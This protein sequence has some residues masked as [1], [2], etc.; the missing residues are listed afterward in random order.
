MTFLNLLLLP[1]L[2][3]R[4][5]FDGEGAGGDTGDAGDPPTGEGKPAATPPADDKK[6]V[7]KPPSGSP[8]SVLADL[9]RERDK[10]QAAESEAKRLQGVEGELQKLREAS[11]SESEKA[12]NDAKREATTEERG[13]WEGVIRQTRVESA[14]I[15]AGCTDPEIVSRASVFADLKVTD[16]GAVEALTETVETFKTA[17]P[18][19]FT[20]RVPGGSAD[21]GRRPDTD[22]KPTSLEGA[23]EAHYSGSRPS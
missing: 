13:K 11:Q 8:E 5:L 22:Q 10:R 23:L 19:L 17:H 15:A 6:Q 4:L 2:F 12:I 3:L 7:A 16:Q 1:V 9:A 21:Q 18:T 20:A 14:L